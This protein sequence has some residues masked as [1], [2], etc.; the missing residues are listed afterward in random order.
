M[1]LKDYQRSFSDANKALKISPDFATA[2]FACGLVLAYQPKPD[3]PA[4]IADFTKAIELKDANLMAEAYRNRTH[5]HNLFDKDYAAVIS[6]A[7]E[8]IKLYPYTTNSYEER[9]YRLNFMAI[10]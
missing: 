4:S 10:M 1:Q 8:A 3:Y 9:G 2:Y 7:T 5:L 6:E